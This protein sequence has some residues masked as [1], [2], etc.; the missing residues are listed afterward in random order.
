MNI[1]RFFKKSKGKILVTSA[2]I[3]SE[4]AIYRAIKAAMNEHEVVYTE[5]AL[6]LLERDRKH[7]IR[8]VVSEMDLFK[9]AR[10]ACLARS[11]KKS[12][13][14]IPLMIVSVS[15]SEEDISKE[16][17]LMGLDDSFSLLGKKSNLA[18]LT[19]K[20]RRL[21]NQAQPQPVN[22]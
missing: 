18:D 4:G 3:G 22:I 13:P 17:Q 1:L 9:E 12:F 2:E 14:D 6:V 5:S 11:T 7:K 10:D 15:M 21:L 8:L 16:A 19:A 20:V